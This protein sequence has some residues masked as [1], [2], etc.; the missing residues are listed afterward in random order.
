MLKLYTY[1]IPFVSP[2]ITSGNTFTHR[3][4]L[5][6]SFENSGVT[7]FGEVA[8]LPGFSE[9]QLEPIIS[10]LKLNKDVL[11]N[12]LIQN[13]F[14][15]YFH[16]L[17]QIH[18][19]P[20]LKFGLDTLYHDYQAKKAGLPLVRYLFNNDFSSK[21]NVNATLGI[22]TIENTIEQ[23]RKLSSLGYNTFKL[24]TGEAFEKEYEILEALRSSLPEIKIRIDANQSWSYNQAVEN[25]QRCKHLDIEYCEE[26]LIATER[27]RWKDLKDS[28]GF[29]FAADESFRNKANALQL[30][31]QNAVETFIL[32][33]M[34]FGSFSEINVTKQLST[35]HGISVV[36]TTS[37]ESIIGRTMTAI[38]A[39][40][41]G[42]KKYAHGLATGS[43]LKHDIGKGS[44]ISDGA[45]Y[46]PSE[47]GLGVNVNFK[48]LK[49]IK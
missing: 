30:Q 5:I 17:G 22:D 34:M 46:S 6:I 37:L 48:I 9:F 32:K 10:I 15:Q 1:S 45:F 12:A 7:A 21:V 11:Q 38:L 20:S 49:E 26:P 36:F 14:E 19:I 31:E 43:L 35:S 47:V 29:N 2:F 16:V 8:P 40:G 24:K 3:E 18:N 4:G 27:N 41:W 28:T 42:A 44:H 13:E 39:L 33:P 25:L 23:A